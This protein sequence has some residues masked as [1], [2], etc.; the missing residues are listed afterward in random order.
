MG[1]TENLKE[2]L[3][4]INVA[5][6]VVKSYDILPEIGRSKLTE[7]SYNKVRQSRNNKETHSINGNPKILKDDIK[8]IQVNASNAN[9]TT[10]VEE[11]QV[12][13]DKTKADIVI[14]S[15]ANMEIKNKDKITERESKFTEFKIEDKI[16]GDNS[17]A[18]LTMMISK[19]NQIYKS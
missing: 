10:K 18:R 4:E 5:H 2:R 15:E 17:K 13:I 6:K 12:I 8:I 3:R 19:K 1:T 14:V 7:Y 16:I 9:F 11:L